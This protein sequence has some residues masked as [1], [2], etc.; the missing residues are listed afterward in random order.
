[1]VLI[2]FPIAT[3]WS[4]QR[5]CK[6]YFQYGELG[7]P[8]NPVWLCAVHMS[9]LVQCICSIS[10]FM[11]IRC[12]QGGPMNSSC[13]LFI[14]V[15]K[16]APWTAHALNLS[17]FT[18]RPHQQILP[19]IYLTSQGGPIKSSCSLFILLH[20]VAPSTAYVLY[21]SFK[22]ISSPVSYL[23]STDRTPPPILFSLFT[24]SQSTVH[25]ITRDALTITEQ[26]SM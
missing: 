2:T 12:S 26:F 22:E 4:T 21:L 9:L 18:R 6:L 19:L 23:S 14:L 11:H 15:Q 5:L 3:L 16:V 1:M 20:K 25:V 13:P 7:N 8:A 17:Y 24:L 10:F